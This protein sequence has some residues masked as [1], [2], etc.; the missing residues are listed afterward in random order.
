MKIF[1]MTNLC[2]VVW[3]ICGLNSISRR[4][5]CTFFFF[6]NL[7]LHIFPVERKRYYKPCHVKRMW[8]HVSHISVQWFWGWPRYKCYNWT[9]FM[10]FKNSPTTLFQMI[11]WLSTSQ[12]KTFYHQTVKGFVPTERKWTQTCHV[13]HQRIR[14]RCFRLHFPK[15]RIDPKL[16]YVSSAE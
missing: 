16:W 6:I 2:Y 10:A 14:G 13:K 1:K 5:I 12:T 9:G 7:S 4:K 15:M 11:S 8:C 3:F